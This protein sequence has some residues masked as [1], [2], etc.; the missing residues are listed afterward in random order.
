MNKKKLFALIISTLFF[1]QV[2]VAGE[3]CNKV[4]KISGKIR[5]TNLSD[6]VQTGS[7]WITIKLNRVPFFIRRGRVIGRILEQGVDT[8]SGQPYAI[9]NHNIFFGFNTV[10]AT[11]RD[12]ALLTPT[13]FHNG[14]PCAFDVVEEIT[15]TVGNNLLGAL[16]NNAGSMVAKGSISYCP[17]SNRNSFELSGEVCLDL[18]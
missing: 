17:G 7:I 11:N 9:L 13:R 2:T 15:D 5:T 6:T 3:T 18:K 8:N 16:S 10:L 1:S 4:G 12:L 14:V